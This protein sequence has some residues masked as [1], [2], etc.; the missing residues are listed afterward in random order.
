MRPGVLLIV[1]AIVEPSLKFF[2]F[3]LFKLLC[4]DI[5]ALEIINKILIAF[6]FEVGCL[7][8]IALKATLPELFACCQGKSMAGRIIS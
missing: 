4:F 3:V 7:L 5:S 8:L 6:S 1:V 2:C